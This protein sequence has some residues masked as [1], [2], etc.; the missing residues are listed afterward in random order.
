MM[1]ARR[2]LGRTSPDTAAGTWGVRIQTIADN[3][4]L[5]R[6]SDNQIFGISKRLQGVQPGPNQYIW[7]NIHEWSLAE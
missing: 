7:W 3:G 4:T 2:S 6:W 1:P 5:R